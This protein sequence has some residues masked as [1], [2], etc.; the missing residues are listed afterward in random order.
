M[1]KMGRVDYR[2]EPTRGETS[3]GEKSC[4]RQNEHFDMTEN[5]SNARFFTVDTLQS[6]QVK[7]YLVE[8]QRQ[9]IVHALNRGETI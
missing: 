3:W 6:D 8:E 1:F 9:I 5:T 7:I 2:G 4:Y